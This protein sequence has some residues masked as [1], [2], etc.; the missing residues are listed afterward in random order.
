MNLNNADWSEG[1]PIWL[2]NDPNWQMGCVQIYTQH[3]QLEQHT[4][5]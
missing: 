3:L 5:I 4:E 2:D 1:D